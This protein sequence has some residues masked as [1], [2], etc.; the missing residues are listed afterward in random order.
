MAT[1]LEGVSAD[2]AALAAEARKKSP[3]LKMKA[4]GAMIRIRNASVAKADNVPEAIAAARDVLQTF[5]VGCEEIKVPKAVAISVAGIH[6]LIQHNAVHVE[7]FPIVLDSLEKLRDAGLEEIKVLQCVLSLVTT[8]PQLVDKALARACVLC[9]SLHF[10]RDSTTA[11]IAAA[12]L[13]QIT[14]AV[15][16]RVVIEDQMRETHGES[17]TLHASDGFMLFQDFCLLTNGDA[18]IWLQGLSDMTRT[19]GLELM[20]SALISHPA[21][22]CK[23]DPYASLIKQRVCSLVIKLSSPTISAPMTRATAPLFPVAIRLLRLIHTLIS[24]YHDLLGPESEIFLSM[25]CKFLQPDKL[26]WHRVVS[27]EVVHEIF[28]SPPV[29][30]AFFESPEMHAQ[31]VD[32]FSELASQINNFIAECRDGHESAAQHLPVTAPPLH[33]SLMDK[34]EAPQISHGYILAL[35]FSSLIA[36][37]KSLSSLVQPHGRRD[38]GRGSTSSAQDVNSRQR[39]KML[40][41]CVWNPVLSGFS[42]LLVCLSNETMVEKVLRAVQS[43][44]RICCTL[45][46]KHQRDAFLTALCTASLPANYSWSTDPPPQGWQVSNKNL[47]AVHILLNSAL[48]M[49][50]MMESSWDLIVSTIQQIVAI[51]DLDGGEQ[52]PRSGHIRKPSLTSATTRKGHRCVCAREC[53]HMRTGS[54]TVVAISGST[55]SELPALSAMLAQLFQIT[56]TMSDEALGYLM[57]A[58]WHQ[59]EATLEQVSLAG[60]NHVVFR[61]DAFLFPVSK[62]LEVGL[63]N[64]DR[65]MVFWPMVTAHLIEVSCH[66]HPGL[67]QQGV[68]ALTRLIHA[69]LSHPRQPP[70]QDNPGLQ[71]AILSPLRNLASCPHLQTRRQQLEC[72]MQ[73]L[74]SS[75]PSLAHAW[76]VVIGIISDTVAGNT[77]VTDAS[78]IA[79]AFENLQLIVQDFLPS[80]PVRCMLMLLRTIGHFCRQQ[81]AVNVAL[82]AVGLLWNVADHVSHN[83]VVL[84]EH[85]ELRLKEDSVSS[86]ADLAGH[87]VHHR[88]EVDADGLPRHVTIGGIWRLIYEQLAALCLDE[89]VD[90]RRSASQTLYPTLKTHAHLLPPAELKSVIDDV[91]LH[92]LRCVVQDRVLC[93]P[94]TTTKDDDQNNQHSNTTVARAKT[95]SD[96][97]LASGVL[98]QHHSTTDKKLW[99]ETKSL[100]VSGSAH[101]FVS[102]LEQL[103]QCDGFTRSWS[104]L[105]SLVQSLLED[106]TDAVALA[107]ANALTNLIRAVEGGHEGGGASTHA[108]TMQQALRDAFAAWTSACMRLPDRQPPHRTRTLVAVV[109]CMRPSLGHLRSVLSTE[110]VARAT[111]C[112]FVVVCQQASDALYLT[113]ANEVQEEVLA[114]LLLLVPSADYPHPDAHH[115]PLVLLQLVRYTALVNSPPWLLRGRNCYVGFAVDCIGAFV[116]Q[117]CSYSEEAAVIRS[118]AARAFLAALTPI[119]DAR[120]AG[121]SVALWEVAMDAVVAIIDYG[122]RGLAASAQHTDAAIQKVTEE[123]WE[124]VIVVIEAALF[125]SHPAALT[126]PEGVDVS[127]IADHE[128]LDIDLVKLVCEAILPHTSAASTR[129][130]SRAGVDVVVPAPVL[131]KVTDILRRGSVNMLKRMGSR[132]VDSGGN[133]DHG[134]GHDGRAGAEQASGDGGGVKAEE[135]KRYDTS[136]HYSLSQR[137]GAHG[138][139]RRAFAKACFQALVD[140]SAT[141]STAATTAGTVTATSGARDNHSDPESTSGVSGGEA[142]G[143]TTAPVSSPAA[144]S[145]WDGV[146]VREMAEECARVLE[147]HMPVLTSYELTD[148]DADEVL[149]VVSACAS[150]VTPRHR[151]LARTLF[152]LL[153]EA[154]ACSRPDVARAVRGVLSLYQALL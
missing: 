56:H 125:P 68:T 67:R 150:L 145:A 144:T 32:V 59:S 15:F 37:T 19:L 148:Q 154:C 27:L 14:T 39:A 50:N 49:G 61:H 138:V 103:L 86:E 88:R 147:K 20:E 92:T 11:A 133:G 53:A 143:T 54:E 77:R 78:I 91:I 79:L 128:Q 41:D 55:A 35:C 110:E 24:A 33:L 108:A 97:P 1:L 25:L 82:T 96:S 116:T 94:D 141:T 65:I 135:Q 18:P 46:L 80:L 34:S 31:S 69:A 3:A 13:R 26:L 8:T 5:I 45:N 151:A 98:V 22:F 121:P 122:L 71:Q 149:F 6:R 105:L 111:E 57:A 134:D 63:A 83:R 99:A 139:L 90:V 43:A 140:C 40:F 109:G 152:P 136:S 95:A 12:T 115:V 60:V 64:L 7:S 102:A 66:S 17:S 101:V 112:L 87:P 2:L 118:G 16:D 28:K 106:E 130:S 127:K 129:G 142:V 132:G 124:Q 81:V 119:V 89:R 72:V 62:L 4:E 52:P 137:A 29:L 146:G 30:M 123:L 10:S 76:P 51:L 84:Q 47:H 23:H 93:E 113:R 107:S 44:I 120:Y 153:V 85:I 73:V 74:D 126:K 131:A 36:L 100:A 38:G 70:I 58:L 114:T 117:F 9:F 21:V 42:M 104:M 48:C 75:G